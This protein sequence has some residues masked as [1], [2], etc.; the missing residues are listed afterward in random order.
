MTPA[1]KTRHHAL[2]KAGWCLR[3]VLGATFMLLFAAA[4]AAPNPVTV[5]EQPR[6]FGYFLG[7][8][9]QQRVLLE[10]QDGTFQPSALPKPQRLGV[11]LERLASRTETD[12]SGRTWLVVDYQVINAGSTLSTVQIPAWSIKGSK[13]KNTGGDAVLTIASWPIHVAA[14][15]P[16]GAPTLQT[17]RPDRPAPLIATGP[18]VQQLQLWLS[19]LG[20]TLIAWLAWVL[21]RNQRAAAQQPFARA[22][23]QLR[24]M[25]EA[26]A[27]AWQSLHRAF[28]R[29]AGRVVQSASLDKLFQAAPHFKGLRPEIE[30]FF[31][32]SEA[33][34]FSANGV[35]EPIDLRGLCSKLRRLE[36]R[37][38]R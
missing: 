3:A 4:H 21:W 1:R 36:K 29:S 17:L 20:L 26:E 34:F 15:T 7:D 22:W 24:G 31:R 10:Q 25:K 32:R 27:A 33:F 8:R 2:P 18:I 37:Q 6:A 12:A 11:W 19:A 35:S 13:V 5:V 14:L 38:E 28:D 9:L 23:R 16:P 30:G